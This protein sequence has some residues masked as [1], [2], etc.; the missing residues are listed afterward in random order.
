M[1][2]KFFN[3]K[4]SHIKMRSIAH[5]AFFGKGRIYSGKIQPYRSDNAAL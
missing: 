1:I 3:L 2:N 4:F 5:L